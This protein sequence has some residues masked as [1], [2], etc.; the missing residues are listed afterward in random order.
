MSSEEW[1]NTI[2]EDVRS[3]MRIIYSVICKCYRHVF[4]K[5]EET[6]MRPQ[7]YEEAGHDTA[8]YFE[9][10][11]ED[12]DD[13]TKYDKEIKSDLTLAEKLSGALPKNNES[14]KK[15]SNDDKS[16]NMAVELKSVSDDNKNLLHII[17]HEINTQTNDVNI[18]EN[19]NIDN[20]EENV[21]EPQPNKEETEAYTDITDANNPLQVENLEKKDS[22]DDESMGDWKISKAMYNI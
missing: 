3:I 20:L 9:E 10:D 4:Q 22:F 19:S 15:R 16:K 11:E 12:S 6:I 17:E 13:E 7:G 8:D 5:K 14:Y 1:V 21:K 18:K 2:K